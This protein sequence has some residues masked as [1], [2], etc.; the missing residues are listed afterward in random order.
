MPDANKPEKE[1][2]FDC[3]L[4]AT[5]RVKATSRKAAEATIRDILDGA[6]CNGGCWPNGDPVLF[7]VGIEGDLDLSEVDG[8]PAG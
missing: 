1:Y 2:A 6:S 7:E 4:L 3:T 8:V 5:L